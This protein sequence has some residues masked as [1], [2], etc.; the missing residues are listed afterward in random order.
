MREI[1]HFVATKK[2]ASQTIEMALY[3]ASV[4]MVILKN[5]VVS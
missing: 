2:S 4:K 1:V 3:D 5:L